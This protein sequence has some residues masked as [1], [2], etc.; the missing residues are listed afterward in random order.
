MALRWGNTLSYRNSRALLAPGPVV[1]PASP[2]SPD[3]YRLKMSRQVVS[4]SMFFVFFNE[5]QDF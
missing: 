4:L 3:I 2:D 5:R 1:G